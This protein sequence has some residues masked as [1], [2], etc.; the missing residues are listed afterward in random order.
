HFQKS[1]NAIP[2]ETLAAIES[3]GVALFGATSSPSTKVEGYRSPILA[4]RKAFD[5][6]A[7]L[8]PI[9]SLPGNFSR[10]NLDLLIVREN[11][12]GLYAGRE[13]MEDADTAI[14]ERVITRKG[15]SRIARVAYEQADQRA[16][17]KD[18]RLTI[19]HKANVLKLTDGLFRE[20]CLKVAKEFPHI[21]TKEML[22]DAMSMRLVK[23]PESFDVIV[24]TNLFGDILSDEASALIGGLGVAPSA[25]IGAKVAVFEPVHGSAPDIMGQGIANPIGAILSSAMMLHHLKQGDAASRVRRAVDETLKAGVLP[26]DLGGKATTKEVTKAVSSNL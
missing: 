14:A 21:T 16:K 15:S 4:M 13:R 8:R 25:N 22:V 7:N 9:Q 1:G 18:Q 12:E 6:Y 26:K 23:D 10:P 17:I 11:T 5:L 3:A 20:E 2:D 24:T 19:V